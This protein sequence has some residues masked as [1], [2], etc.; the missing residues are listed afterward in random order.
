MAIPNTHWTARRARLLTQG[1]A[2]PALG[3]GLRVGSRRSQKVSMK[4]SRSSS[5][6][7]RR[8]MVRSTSLKAM[9]ATTAT[10]CRAT[11]AGSCLITCSSSS[12]VA[13]RALPLD[14]SVGV[15]PEGVSVL[16]AGQGI[17]AQVEL[18]ESLGADT[19][20]HARVGRDSLLVA[21]Q[22]ERSSLKPGETVGLAFSG[23]GLH[24]FDANAVVIMCSALGQESLVMEAIEAGASDF[25]VKPFRAEDVLAV[26]KKVLGEG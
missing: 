20:I 11:R 1:L 18:V 10:Q 21:R 12:R 16:P 13:G 15:R 2:V 19:L 3:L 5:L 9:K 24:V 7:T 4:L 22:S 17:P 26:V 23:E 25:I 6:L 8:P 14:G